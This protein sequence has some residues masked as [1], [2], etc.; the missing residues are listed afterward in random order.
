MTQIFVLLTVLAYFASS[1]LYLSFLYTGKEVTG[2]F[3]TVLMFLGLACH[4]VS[5]LGRAKAAH[6]VPYHDLQG[7]MSLFG[8]LLAVIYLVFGDLSSAA[9]RGCLCGSDHPGVL[10]GGEPGAR[11]MRRRPRRHMGWFSRC[12]S[13]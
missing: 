11:I 12:T 9:D 8:W 3:A 5:L 1:G 10:F 6:S 2:R 13:R 4:Y 7:S